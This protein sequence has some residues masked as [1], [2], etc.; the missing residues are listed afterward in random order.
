MLAV[1]VA[2]ERPGF[3]LD[4]QFEL[5]TPGVAALFGPS[6]CGK[7]TTIDIIAGLVRPDRA[8]ITLDGA[9]LIDTERRVD[10]PAEARRIGYVFQ[11]SRLFPHLSVAGN[12]RYAARRAAGPAYVG[13]DRVA[14]MLD[15]G[16][17]MAR[18]VHQLSGG[19]KQ[20]VAIGRAL[21]A[22][23]RLLLLDE[24]LA[25]LDRER[26][27][28]VLPYLETLRDQLAIPM[29]YVSHRWE[30]VA[31]LA[32]HIIVM[33]AG[34]VAARGDIGALCLDRELRSLVGPD[35]VGVILEGE[36]LGRDAGGSL[37]VRIAQGELTVPG[38]A[39]A[40]SRLRIEL[41]ARDVIVATQP[42]RHLG[43]HNHLRGVVAALE[44]DGDGADL[45]HIDAG[46]ARLL[47]RISTAACRDLALVPGMTVWALIT[48]LSLRP[49]P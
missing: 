21:L 15:L 42:P 13:F 27:E 12:L 30:E 2:K 24:P 19:E 10:V 45:V 28:E 18:R 33:R 20:R 11:N 29:V 32:T 31:R 49:R 5:P 25:A 9:V 22:Q 3:A 41:L 37:R 17:L 14:G 16:R 7:S 48:A 43:I 1:A 44:E 26:R 40:G 6:G 39:A 47:A 8:R 23:P 46:G 35:S 4:V 34:R 36:V 38:A